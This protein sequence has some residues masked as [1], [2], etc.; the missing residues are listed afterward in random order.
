[1]SKHG[2]NGRDFEIHKGKTKIAAVTTKTATRGREAVDVT[3]DDDDG[4]RRLLP[5]PGSRSLDA[6]VEGV[7]TSENWTDLRDMA[8]SDEF[9]DIS[10]VNPDGTTEEAEDGFFLTELEWEGEQDGNVA[11]TMEMQS[12]G[13]ITISDAGQ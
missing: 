9:A 10:I 5:K 2:Y 13:P 11:F 6:S 8:D 12:S 3:T 7:V 4:N 1:M